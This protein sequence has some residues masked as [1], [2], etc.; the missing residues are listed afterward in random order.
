MDHGATGPARQ[1]AGRAYY[2]EL[3]EW[4]HG[5][6]IA[7]LYGN[8]SDDDA[9]RKRT[10]R[11]LARLEAAGLVERCAWDRNITHAK[12]TPAATGGGGRSRRPPNDPGPP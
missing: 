6:R 9:L 8:R 5:P 11:A 7:R 2:S 1:R 12:L 4:E 10:N 3:M